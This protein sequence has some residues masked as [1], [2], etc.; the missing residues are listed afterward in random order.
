MEKFE[1]ISVNYNTPDLVDTMIES[2]RK[3][4]GDYPIRIIDGSDREPYKTKTKEVCEKYY[5]VKLNQFGWNIHHGRGLDFGILSSTYDW[6]LC[7]DS[8]SSLSG[9]GLFKALQFKF[10]YEG[11]PCY[12]NEFGIDVNKDTPGNILYLHPMFLLVDTKHYRT[13]PYKFVHHGAPAIKI[14]AGNDNKDKYI[15]P[16]EFKQYFSRGGRGTVNRFGYNL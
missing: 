5:N 2:I 9:H 11:F 16:D 3:Y 4:E 14:M 15:I 8:D 10:K 6:V 12:V 13:S 1:I 7:F